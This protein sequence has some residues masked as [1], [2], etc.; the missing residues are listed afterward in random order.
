MYF[1]RILAITP[2]LTPGGKP[3]VSNRLTNFLNQT[4]DEPVDL[5]EDEFDRL[6]DREDLRISRFV[7]VRDIDLMLLILTNR[8][9]ISPALSAYSILNQAS[10]EALA[11][12]T[13]SESGIH[14][15]TLDADLSLRG[16]LMSEVVKQ[17]IQR[18]N[19]G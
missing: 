10:D 17:I 8:R 4:D 15:P 7:R 1:L 12:Y 5:V 16:L 3:S 13:I 19:T 18:S 2:S 9:V 11:N 14:W 6:I